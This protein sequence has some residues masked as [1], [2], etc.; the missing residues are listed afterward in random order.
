MNTL[1]SIIETVIFNK[2]TLMYFHQNI[3]IQCGWTFE[4]IWLNLSWSLK[5]PHCLMFLRCE[6]I[7][8]SMSSTS[9]VYTHLTPGNCSKDCTCNGVMRWDVQQ[10]AGKW[11]SVPHS[12]V[13]RWH[14]LKYCTSSYASLHSASM[15][16]FQSKKRGEKKQTEKV[17]VFTGATWVIQGTF[18]CLSLSF[19]PALHSEFLI[20]R[21]YSY[22]S[23]KWFGRRLNVINTSTAG[24][25]LL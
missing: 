20:F 21:S 6:E 5:A 7:L 3:H 14:T 9:S 17:F 1:G 22:V 15:I 11:R 4:Y 24:D 18:S 16:F 25:F 2:T 19:F 8:V 13:M 12:W 10:W 23:W